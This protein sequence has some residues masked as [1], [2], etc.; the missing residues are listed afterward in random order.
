MTAETLA[1]L[2]VA[3]PLLGAVIA[4]L[5]PKA[6]FAITVMSVLLVGIGGT[7]LRSLVLARG[8][9]TLAIGGWAA[10][11]GIEWHIDGLS[12]ALMLTTTVVGLAVSLYAS[13]YFSGA[14]AG[15]IFFWPL[16][17]ILLASLCVTFVS[18]DLFHWYVA[19]ELLSLSAVALITLAEDRS[20]LLGAQRYLFASLAGSLSYLLGVSMVYVQCGTLDLN[21]L[22]QAK[23]EGAGSHA[24]I[25]LMLAGLLMKGAIFPLHGW[26]PSAHGSAPAPVSALL[27]ALVVKGALFIALR[28]WLDVTSTPASI[29]AILTVLGVVAI[30]WGSCQALRTP[31][32]K[33][34]VAW[35]T[36]AQLGYLVLVFPLAASA[37]SR[38]LALAGGVYLIISHA[39]A[40]AAMF[41]AAGTIQSCAGHD[42]IAELGEATQARPMA[43]C[44]FGI[45]AASVLGLP[46]SGGFI[47]K[48]TLLNAVIADRQWFLLVVMMIG[49]LLA[50]GYSFRVL[51]LGFGRE[52]GAAAPVMRQRLDHRREWPSL[53]LALV[54]LVLGFNAFPILDLIQSGPG[55]SS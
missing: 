30:V 43:L 37:A 3:A 31:R 8:P 10:P 33:L 11:L 15:R 7:G 54:A 26:L 41:L 47:A 27:S 20:A 21:L 1:T 12:V 51:A 24:A 4:F 52:N 53:F 22:A 55:V 40:K 50:A 42:R 34:L 32:L 46:P 39:C 35:S 5:W 13:G 17:L 2:C 25:V 6:G 14:S 38:E 28:I 18:N 44:A 23:L 16:W 45:A 29:S 36:I 9:I 48:W 19:L 49:G